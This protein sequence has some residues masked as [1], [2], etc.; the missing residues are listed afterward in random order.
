MRKL[1][2]CFV[3]VV[4]AAMLFELGRHQKI[5]SKTQNAEFEKAIPPRYPINSKSNACVEPNERE[6]AL[7][8]TAVDVL[9]FSSKESGFLS[10]GAEKFLGNGLYR[11]DGSSS[12]RVCDIPEQMERASDLIRSSDHL[13]RGRIV[14]YGLRLIAKL[15][16]PGETLAK[17]AAESAFNTSPQQSEIFPERDIRPLARATLASLGPLARPYADQAY[18][19][20]SID[21]AMGTGA[22]QVAVA[23]GH[24]NALQSVE[25][26]MAQKLASL[27]EGKA[28]PW[29]LRNR[30]YEM[31]YALAFGGTQ[32]REHVAPLRDLMSLKVQSW[33]PPFGMVEL[34][35]RR[36]CDVFVQIMQQPVND[37]EFGFC[38]DNGPYEQ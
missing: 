2:I 28:V 13:R 25:R 36:M 7:I 27:P 22:A 8:K 10:T 15:P 9:A 31:A 3:T 29:D 38:S 35:P 6:R 1:L 37:L 30:L 4:A 16:N 33:A 21:D 20:I 18:A 19:Q 12:Q 23:G 24:P 5:P 11:W 26:L 32:A 14:E 34:P 17:V